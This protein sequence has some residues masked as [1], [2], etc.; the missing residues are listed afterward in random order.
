MRGLVS[1]WRPPSSCPSTSLISLFCSDISLAL[2]LH[3]AGP[4]RSLHTPMPMP[5]LPRHRRRAHPLQTMLAAPLV[6]LAL[7]ALGRPTAAQGP[8]VT[9][10][11]DDRPPATVRAELRVPSQLLC[12]LARPAASADPAHFLLLLPPPLPPD[13]RPAAGTRADWRPRRCQVRTPSHRPPAPP[14][15]RRAVRTRTT[16]AS[17]LTE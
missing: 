2:P 5:M 15:L 12:V 4:S 10:N 11:T 3:F 6:V 13:G 1:G 16:V 7:L 14:L 9:V 8:Q 17:R